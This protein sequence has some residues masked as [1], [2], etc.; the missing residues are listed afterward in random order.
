[1]REA[2]TILFDIVDRMKE[3][4]TFLLLLGPFLWR[5]VRDL[6]AGRHGLASSTI[7]VWW[8]V[9]WIGSQQSRWLYIPLVLLF[10]VSFSDED[11]LTSRGVWLG[12]ILSVVLTSLSVFRANKMDFWK[13]RWETLRPQDQFLI[14]SKDTIDEAGPTAIQDK[15]AAYA[16]YEVAVTK[17][18]GAWV[19]PA[20]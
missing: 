5:I 7:I 14:L 6:R 20:R 11:I 16:T 8:A 1:V 18:D 2:E 4:P 13:T 9:W 3:D 12:L 10:I 19:L 15:E 17:P